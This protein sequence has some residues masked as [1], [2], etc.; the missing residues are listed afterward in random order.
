MTLNNFFYPQSYVG[1]N[2][3]DV[4]NSMR[5]LNEACT[6]R[7]EIDI[8]YNDDSF[9]N[10]VAPN[11][12]SFYE[13]DP[14][15]FQRIIPQTLKM[16]RV[17]DNV[18]GDLQAINE[19]FANDVNSLWGFFIPFDIYHNS[20]YEQYKVHREQIIESNVSGNNFK[21]WKI[22][23]FSKIRFTDDCLKQIINLGSSLTF[24]KVFKALIELDAYNSSWENGNF[25]L[26]ELKDICS[27]EVSDESDTVKQNPHLKSERLFS[28]PDNLGSKY[29][30]LHIKIKSEGSNWRIH[31]YP[32]ALS[33]IIYVAYV[34]SHLTLG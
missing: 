3:S 8:F 17:C 34:G 7:S 16:M 15:L 33:K 5:G 18:S 1:K 12:K 28:L 29:C 27:N 30:F 14:V 31:F 26:Q 23:L 19:K 4:V 24:Q 9:Y 32:D 20:S 25:Q 6:K 13:L 11:Y 22:V 21:D 10:V 2:T